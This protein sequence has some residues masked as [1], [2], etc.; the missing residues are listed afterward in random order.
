ML[1]RSFL[2][3][4]G[5]AFPEKTALQAG[6]E[7]LSYGQ[8]GDAVSRLAG[9]LLDLGL[10]PGDRMAILLP[11]SLELATTVL[12][13]WRAEL[14]VVPLSPD[15]APP[16][17]AAILAET[18]ARVL[19]ASSALKRSIP[20]PALASLSACVLV[21]GEAPDGLPY[22]RLLAA[23]RRSAVGDSPD[24]IGLIAFTSGTTGRPK[25]IAHSQSRLA[26]RVDAFVKAMALTADDVTLTIFPAARPVCLV[27]QFLAM[28][29]VGGTQVLAER[30]ECGDFWSVYGRTAPTYCLAMPA[31][32]RKL[33]A[34]PAAAEADHGRL[35][36][37]MLGGDQ[38]D[39][40]L[41][42]KME[43]LTGRPFL[44]TFGLTE[45][46][47]VSMHPGHGPVKRGSVGKPLDG[48]EMRLVGPD[49]QE[50][51]VGTPGRLLVR[52]PNMMIGYWNDTLRTHQALGTGWLDTQDILQVDEDGYYWFL[53]RA[54]E[55]IVRNAVNVSSAQVIEA[56]AE[57][58]AVEEAALVG[59]PDPVAG[60]AP[61]AFYRVRDSAADP[62][63]EVLRVWVSARVDRESVPVACHRIDHWPMT[64]QGKLDRRRLASMA[65]AWAEEDG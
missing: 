21:D 22:E 3:D 23:P 6:Q 33:L 19:V 40:E 26:A 35:R 24:P 37:W 10:C 55:V 28:L 36:F 57:H 58:P 60:Q 8:L 53:G 18:G 64:S 51:G 52:T 39:P 65:V 14:I 46:G 44:N 13:A 34:H 61:V 47:A 25:G 42:R 54:S 41:N 49:G 62:G 15:Y 45:A 38:P 2:D 63:G 9:G 5:G 7:T 30:P 16:Q 43:R 50:A 32:A 4:A 56:L 17:H 29:R 20:P 48:V 11:N 31:Y 27:H 12:A 1:I 59:V